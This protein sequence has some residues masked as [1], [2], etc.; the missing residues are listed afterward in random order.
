MPSKH[1]IIA[2]L[3]GWFFALLVNPTQIL[4]MGRGLVSPSRA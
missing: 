4:G 3:V 2:F 1:T